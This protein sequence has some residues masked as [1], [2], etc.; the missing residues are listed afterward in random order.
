MFDWGWKA[1]TE[2]VRGVRNVSGRLFNVPD[3][4]EG[5]VRPSAESWRLAQLV[6]VVW[7]RIDI[8]ISF[9]IYTCE[10]TESIRLF[11]YRFLSFTD[12]KL[13]RYEVSSRP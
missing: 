12:G 1:W 10:V 5:T 11:C 4:R 2:I 6:R 3:Y 13:L 9:L 7:E 8:L